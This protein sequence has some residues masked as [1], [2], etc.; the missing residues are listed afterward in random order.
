MVT[1]TPEQTSSSTPTVAA[2]VTAMAKGKNG[3]STYTN[4][5][6]GFSFRFPSKMYVPNGSP[7]TKK[8]IAGDWTYQKVS[9]VVPAT[10]VQD[11]AGFWLVQATGYQL[12]EHSTKTKNGYLEDYYRSCT[13]R[14]TTVT[15][16]R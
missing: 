5:E 8:N 14:T 4:V 10:V 13:T 9:G 1:A 3:W 16:L 11:G 12:G 15:L 7:C 6:F 2:P